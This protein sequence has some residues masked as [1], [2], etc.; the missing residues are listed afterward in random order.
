MVIYAYGFQVTKVNLDET[1][2]PRRQEQRVRILRALARP[3]LFEYEKDEFEVNVPILVPCPSGEF[4]VPEPDRSGPYMVL[5]PQCAAPQTA[6]RVEGFNFEPRTA[7]P[8][9]F[10]PPSEVKLQMGSI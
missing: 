5:T 3:D 8:I 6:I 2:S 1:R 7:G 4:T 9:L 10:I